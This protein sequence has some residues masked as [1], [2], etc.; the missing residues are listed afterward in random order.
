MEQEDRAVEVDKRAL[1]IGQRGFGVFEAIGLTKPTVNMEVE[2]KACTTMPQP[3][4]STWRA[5][6]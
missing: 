6:M 4:V 2:A 1:Q 3:K 5:H